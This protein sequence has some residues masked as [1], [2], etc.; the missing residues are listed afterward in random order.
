[1]EASGRWH[2]RGRPVVY[3][4]QTL[5]LAALEYLAHLGRRDTKASFVWVQATIPGD[6]D[7]N[8]L[9]PATLPDHWNTSPPIEAT[10]ALGTAWLAAS[11]S[12]VL[13]VPSAVIESEFNFL[14]NPRHPDFARIRVLKPKAFSFDS[15][16]T[17]RA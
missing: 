10:M 13:K 6:V 4:A 14:L 9:D 8:I 15:R 7:V 1:M 16:L 11:R 17:S 12:A 2:H 5:S 3:A